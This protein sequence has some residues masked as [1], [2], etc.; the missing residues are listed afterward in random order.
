MRGEKG[1]GG[2]GGREG[3]IARLTQKAAQNTKTTETRKAMTQTILITV[4]I[5]LDRSISFFA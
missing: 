1:G 5:A 3:E 4:P 2:E